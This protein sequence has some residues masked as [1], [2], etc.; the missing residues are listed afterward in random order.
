MVLLQ[1]I[2]GLV[3]A[4]GGGH[5]VAATEKLRNQLAPAALDFDHHDAGL[6]LLLLARLAAAR[7]LLVASGERTPDA[8]TQGFDVADGFFNV[9]LRTDIQGGDRGIIG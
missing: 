3:A 4:R 8:K 6:F 5:V 2:Q 7:Q 9:V 1:Q